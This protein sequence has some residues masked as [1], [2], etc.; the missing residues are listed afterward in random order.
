M[1]SRQIQSQTGSRMTRAKYGRDDYGSAL[2]ST[3]KG[4]SGWKKERLRLRAA[5]AAHGIARFAS[6]NSRNTGS[7]SWRFLAAQ[8]AARSSSVINRLRASG[9]RSE[10]TG[11]NR[12]TQKGAGHTHHSAS[13]H[14][15]A[16]L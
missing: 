7:P 16:G 9:L 10:G 11:R 5:S 1:R 8:E 4:S 3:R 2:S 6:C 14:P 13:L 12:S 15:S